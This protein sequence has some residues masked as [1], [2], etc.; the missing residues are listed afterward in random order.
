MYYITFKDSNNREHY[1][2]KK[3]RG[4]PKVYTFNTIQTAQKCK[5][6]FQNY[7]IEKLIQETVDLFAASYVMQECAR[8]QVNEIPPKFNME[9]ISFEEVMKEKGYEI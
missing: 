1:F 7:A 2:Y 6:L 4:K 9:T 8:L 5:E 3:E